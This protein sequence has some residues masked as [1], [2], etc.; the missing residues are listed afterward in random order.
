MITYIKP[1]LASPMALAQRRCLQIERSGVCR[2][3]FA[4]WP[5]C[6]GANYVACLGDQSNGPQAGG[7]GSRRDHAGNGRRMAPGHR[8][9]VLPDRADAHGAGGRSAAEQRDSFLQARAGRHAAGRGLS[10][11]IGKPREGYRDEDTWS[12]ARPTRR[13]WARRAGASKWG[14][15]TG[16]DRP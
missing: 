6:A 13:C 2:A 4:A 14:A 3:R 8:R 7:R 12:A 5:V 11:T 9:A 1:L 16:R 10:L 15:L